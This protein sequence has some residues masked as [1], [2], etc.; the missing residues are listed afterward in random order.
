MTNEERELHVLS[1]SEAFPKLRSDCYCFKQEPELAATASSRR[2]MIPKA[3]IEHRRTPTHVLP[4]EG[5]LPL[6]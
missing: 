5:L 1:D 6:A 2:I 4:I 3:R